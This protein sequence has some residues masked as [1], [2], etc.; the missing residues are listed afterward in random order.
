METVGVTC[1]LGYEVQGYGFITC[2][3][4][5][6]WSKDAKCVIKGK[7]FF[8]CIYFVINLDVR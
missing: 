2:L 8:R 6:T 5:R 1:D 4:N 7:Q 3:G